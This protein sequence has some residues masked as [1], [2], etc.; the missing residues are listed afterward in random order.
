ME[1]NIPLVLSELNNFFS[2]GTDFQI[3]IF[4]KWFVITCIPLEFKICSLRN[5]QPY[6]SP[7]TAL[8]GLLR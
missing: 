5:E 1:L 7:P 8:F 3:C 6:S 4:G 2:Y